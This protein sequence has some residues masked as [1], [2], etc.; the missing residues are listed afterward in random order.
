MELGIEIALLVLLTCLSGYFSGSETALFSLPNTKLKA[1]ALDNDPRKQQIATLLRRPQDLLVTVFMLNTLV[2]ILLQNV[3]SNMFGSLASWGLKVGVPLVI[4]L[5]VGEMIPK[6]FGMQHN[7]K[8][9]YMVTPSIIF[10]QNLLAPARKAVVTITAPIS[11]FMFFFLTKEESISREELLHVLKTSE[12]LEVLHQEE[13]DLVC[14]YLDL[15][16]AIVK[17]LMRPRQEVLFYIIEEPLSQLMHLF[18]DQ[19]CSRITFV[20]GR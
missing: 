20:R 17:E 7:I 16:D 11:R 3:A 12:E 18:V 9:S 6:S 10:F 1:Y 5:I 13:V 2:N 4:T 8:L 15:Q 19:K 14:G